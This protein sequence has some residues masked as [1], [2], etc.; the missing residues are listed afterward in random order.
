MTCGEFLK[1]FTR[2]CRGAVAIIFGICLL[3]ISLT[4]G[5]A[6][7]FARGSS[8]QVSLQNDLDAAVLSAAAK[9]QSE[10]QLQQEAQDYFDENWKSK[11]GVEGAV[12]VSVQKTNDTQIRGELTV[13]F[14]TSFMTLAGIK[15]VPVSVASSIEL[16]GENVEMALVLDVTDS[17]AGA[18]IDALKTSATALIDQIYANDKAKDRVKISIVPFADYVNIGD[19]N[20]NASWMSVPLDSSETKT[21]CFDNY[22]EVT[23]TSNCRMETF[24]GNRDGI[25]YTYEAQVCDYQY[26]PPQT[27]CFDNTYVT[28]WYGCA[29]SRDYPLDVRDEDFST[30]VPGV[31]NVGCG[32][33][34]TSLTNDVDVLRDRI[35]A[36]STFGNTYIPA[37]LFWGWTT[38]SSQEPFTEAAAYGA[39]VD[40]MPVQ[41]AMVLMTDG[42]NTRSPDYVNKTH[43][44]A[45]VLLANDRTAELCTNIKDAGI[46]MYTVAFDVMDN[47]IKDILR[48]C[49]SSPSNF[50]D[51]HDA[52]ELQAAFANI[53][54]GLA[55]LR[56][57]Q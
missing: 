11:H 35:N 56:I 16:A 27:K 22:Q 21:E 33:P 55:P 25:P 7:D 24:T 8:L 30:P 4:V 13:Q 17:M 29:G 57:A 45:D 6:I 19:T 5:L 2:D 36:I 38:L 32:A 34:G 40:G 41:K 47:T 52:G 39:K 23:G 1:R 10:S 12:A 44:G 15:T 9:A 46:K 48:D 43:F 50:F 14:P 51:A 3:A 26:G 42:A 37:G 53:G 49:A 28:Q 31:M 20:R 18:K 54:A